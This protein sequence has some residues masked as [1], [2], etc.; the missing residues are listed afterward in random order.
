MESGKVSVNLEAVNLTTLAEEVRDN[1]QVLATE[2]KQTIELVGDDNIIATADRVLLPQALVNIIHNAIRY[3]P[4][5]TRISIRT[6]RRDSRP[7]IEISDQGPGI[8]PDHQQKIFERFY[9]VDKSRARVEGGNGLGLAIAKWS[10]ERQNGRIEVV[11]EVG[12]GSVFRV[13]LPG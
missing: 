8:G 6:L 13:M 4:P 7:L 9:R 2:K 1:L 3:S 11:S 5:D 12:R 10:V